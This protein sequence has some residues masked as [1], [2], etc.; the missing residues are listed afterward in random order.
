MLHRFR[1]IVVQ[2]DDYAT[3]SNP[4][5]KLCDQLIPLLQGFETWQNNEVNKTLVRQILHH[6]LTCTKSSSQTVSRQ[7]L[8]LTSKL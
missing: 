8:T 4:E 5:L 7:Q 1:D 2:S 6:T 3:V